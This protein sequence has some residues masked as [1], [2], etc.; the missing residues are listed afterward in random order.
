MANS[1][2]QGAGGE[3]MQVKEWFSMQILPRPKTTSEPY[4]LPH[5]LSRKQR[6]AQAQH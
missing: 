3:K 4:P 6:D 5:A 1:K 2:Y